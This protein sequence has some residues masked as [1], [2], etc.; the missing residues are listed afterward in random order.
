MEVNKSHKP[1]LGDY[2]NNWYNKDYLEL[3]SNRFELGKVKDVLD[4]GCGKFH[5]TSL[6]S[7]YFNKDVKITGIDISHLTEE[8]LKQLDS[9]RVK[10]V[11]GNSE[12]LP[13]AD[14]SFDFVTCQTLLI[15]LKDPLVTLKEMYRV[16]LKKGRV[17]ISEPNNIVQ[18]VFR[19]TH[20]MNES[21]EERIIRISEKMK[22][23]RRKVENS[24]GDNSLGELVPGLLEKAGFR[25]VNCFIN[26]KVNIMK[27]PYNTDEEKSKISMLEK[28]VESY[29][30]N[31]SES[32]IN[33]I[34]E[35]VK[36][37]RDNEFT[38]Y[39]PTMLFIS[40][41]IKK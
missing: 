26:D 10:F 3:I 4:V 21:L 2:R 37:I 24:S 38:A 14:S 6:L 35:V 17:C 25:D 18:S 22:S 39:S 9:K 20:N 27:P 30:Y 13:F 28:L 16:L 33:E 7:E 5:W 29:P 36:M 1:I 19:N 31:F 8:E 11:E 40:T 34:D 23:E 41:G 15:H 12:K 32:E